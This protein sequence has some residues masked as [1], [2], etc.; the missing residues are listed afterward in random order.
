MPIYIYRAQEPKIKVMLH[1]T[2]FNDNFERNIV[3]Q[4]SDTC[5]MA[6]AD[7]FERNICYHNVLYNFEQASNSYNVV[8]TN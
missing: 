6:S 8:A 1:G 5:N 2:I 7:D 3:A 4:K